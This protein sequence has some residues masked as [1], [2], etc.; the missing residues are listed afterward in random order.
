[1]TER[2]LQTQVTQALHTLGWKTQH[3]YRL[4]TAADES[5]GRPAAWRTSTTA[6]GWPDVVAVRPGW[7][8]AIEVKSA[9]GAITDEQ[10]AW[11]ALL[12]SLPFCRAWV[13]RPK[14]DPAVWMRWMRRPEGAPRR[15]GWSQEQAAAALGRMD[16]RA[17]R[18]QSTGR[19]PR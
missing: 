4:Q 15:Y 17:A 7:Q 16:R 18:R 9:K 5:K 19:L 10:L 6:S 1:M 2:E 11:L 12:A 14:D 8:L 13:L 3:V